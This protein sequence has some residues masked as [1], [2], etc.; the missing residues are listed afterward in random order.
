MAGLTAL[1][2]R[3]GEKVVVDHLPLVDPLPPPATNTTSFQ[4]SLTIRIPTA[5]LVEIHKQVATG[6]I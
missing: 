1:K 5:C 3:K 2:S 4:N 6:R